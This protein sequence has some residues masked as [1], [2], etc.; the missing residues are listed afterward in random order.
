MTAMIRMLLL[1]VLVAPLLA[2]A[3]D[4]AWPTRPV[5]VIVPGQAGGAGDIVTRIVA[6]RLG[7]RLKQQFVIDNRPGAGGV[8][9]TEAL[10]RA[11]PAFL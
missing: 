5:R 4:A 6:Q 2:R 1:L 8:I 7:E 3:Q 9:G 11:A 10:A